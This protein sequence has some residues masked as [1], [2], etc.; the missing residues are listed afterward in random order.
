MENDACVAHSNTHS[1]K[2]LKTIEM[3]E[4]WH[5]TNRKGERKRERNSIRKDTN[6]NSHDSALQTNLKL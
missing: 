4:Y 5:T 1:I 2:L 6:A 3:L